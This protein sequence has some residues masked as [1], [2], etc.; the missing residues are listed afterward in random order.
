[1]LFKDYPRKEYIEK[2]TE[3]YRITV[4]E[5]AELS[6]VLDY[7]WS[8]LSR[9]ESS[10]ILSDLL[11]TFHETN[12]G[13][14][15]FDERLMKDVVNLLNIGPLDAMDLVQIAAKVPLRSVLEKVMDHPSCPIELKFDVLKDIFIRQKVVDAKRFKE[16]AI[17]YFTFDQTAIL[18]DAYLS[19]GLS[20]SHLDDVFIKYVIENS[21]R[22]TPILALYNSYIKAI[23]VDLKE[24]KKTR[25][26]EEYE[27]QIDESK[28]NKIADVLDY[29]KHAIERLAT[30]P[31]SFTIDEDGYLLEVIFDNTAIRK[32]NKETREVTEVNC[33]YII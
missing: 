32:Y 28:M 8:D 18:T 16:Y 29:T 10:K 13:I 5:E 24:F 22:A 1:M 19:V 7:I 4:D 11:D 14:I 15:K 12:F 30:Q 3:M 33:P 25:S 20:C 23:D 6:V 26:Y 9:F 31:I 27:Y 17:K 21:T 2:L